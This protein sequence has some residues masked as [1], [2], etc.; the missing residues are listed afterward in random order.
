MAE[1]KNR[2]I[3]PALAAGV[4]ATIAVVYS[5]IVAVIGANIQAPELGQAGVGLVILLLGAGYM[6]TGPSYEQ[7]SALCLG[8]L[9][10]FAILLGGLLLLAPIAGVL[11]PDFNV[12]A[13]WAMLILAITVPVSTVALTRLYRHAGALPPT[14]PGF[15]NVVFGVVGQCWLAG[16][17]LVA[18]LALPIAALLS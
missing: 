11:M 15:W 16:Y 6:A 1:Q 10:V 4:M 17:L 5:G 18:A 8:L 12:T 2:A 3:P 13:M 9:G 14:K 7:F